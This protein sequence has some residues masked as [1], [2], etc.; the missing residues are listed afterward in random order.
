MKLT[1]GMNEERC[2]TEKTYYK[3][4]GKH[5]RLINKSQ[6]Q[7]VRKKNKKRAQIQSNFFFLCD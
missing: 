5:G 7:K 2:S 4:T 1:A 3:R 6:F